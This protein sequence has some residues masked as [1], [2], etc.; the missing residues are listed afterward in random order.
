MPEQPIKLSKE[1]L[2]QLWHV[3]LKSVFKNKYKRIVLATQ[4]RGKIEK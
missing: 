1:K 4:V 3:R 2:F